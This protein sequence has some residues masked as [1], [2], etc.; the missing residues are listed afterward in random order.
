MALEKAGP[1]GSPPVIGIAAS[2]LIT[3]TEP[4]P[5]MER[6]YVNHDYVTAVAA[7][8]AVPLMLP[9]IQDLELI[10][11]QVAATDGIL[12]TGGYDPDPL[13]YGENPNRRIDFIFPEVDEHQLAVIRVANELG[14]PILGICRGL[15]MLNIAFGG[16]LYQDLTLIPGSYI[17]HYQKSRKETRG[18]QVTLTEGTMLAKLFP[19]TVILTNSFHHLA[20]KDLAPG[21]TVNALAPDGVIEGMERES[22]VPVLAVQWHPEMMC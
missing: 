2:L 17:Q 3:A 22:G 21:F 13:L 20:V 1:A 10:R 19:E 15:Q 7:A 6:S 14:K 9:V 5:G 4:F 11:R 8:G 18:H 12:M 16:S